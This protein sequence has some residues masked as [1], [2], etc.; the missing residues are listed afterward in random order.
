MKSLSK[1][2]IVA[3]LLSLTLQS[4]GKLDAG[5]SFI[6]E[7]N[8]VRWRFEVI[9]SK[10][11][12]VKVTP[13]TSASDLHGSVTVP[14][15]AECD[16]YRYTVTQIGANAFRNYTGITSVTLPATISA[17][18]ECAFQGD[19]SLTTI[20]TPQPLS[21]IGNYAFDSCKRLQSFNLKASLSS[22][23][24][25]CFRGCSSL[26][27]V[28]FPTSFSAIPEE[29]F[30]GCI[31]FV[32]ITLPATVMQI[33]DNAF[34]GCSS[35]TSV[36]MDRSVQSIGSGAFSGCTSI[37][38]ITCLTATPP[39]C[40]ASTFGGVPAEASVT[41][42]SASV[43]LYRAAPGWSQFTNYNGVY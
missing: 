40:T 15:E 13:M 41:V 24:K 9:V 2:S 38:A 16:G 3:A 17:I 12:Y 7:V 26:Q 5:D 21:T 28:E 33:G 29:A 27:N 37:E 23:G 34:N 36:Q 14:G 18:E 43:E 4:C 39:A 22:L 10:M 11:R 25:G 6:S 1:I 31:S 35:V 32:D 19:T 20:N 8:G 42:P 30:S